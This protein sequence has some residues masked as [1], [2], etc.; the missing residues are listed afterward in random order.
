MFFLN[1][2]VKKLDACAAKLEPNKTLIP[3]F[4]AD[5]YL[6][7]GLHY[8]NYLGGEKSIVILNNYEASVRYFPVIW[9]DAKLPDVVIGNMGKEGFCQKWDSGARQVKQKADY[10]LIFGEKPGD[11]CYDETVK[12]VWENYLAV[13]KD[14]DVTLYK[15]R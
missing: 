15:L 4:F 5:N 9:N 1:D 7:Q 11:K 6:W 12:V 13:A 10:I 8:C 2:Q 14:R 3:F